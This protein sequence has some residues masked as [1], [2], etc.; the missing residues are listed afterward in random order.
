MKRVL[1]CQGDSLQNAQPPFRRKPA[2]GAQQTRQKPALG[3]AR[4]PQK[5][6]HAK[7]QPENEKHG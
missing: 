1:L 4:T 6:E 3:V 5:K 2:P 7:Q